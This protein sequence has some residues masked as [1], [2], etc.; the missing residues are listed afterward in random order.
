MLSEIDALVAENPL[1]EKLHARRMLALYRAGRQAMALQAYRDARA[2]LVGEVG[3]EPGP[4]LRALHERILRQD[5]ALELAPVPAVTPVPARASGAARRSRRRATAAAMA[6]LLAGFAILGIARGEDE[7]AA[8][9]GAD[10]VGRVAGDGAIAARFAVGRNPGAI[11]A[12]G[13]SIWVASE[14]DR[15]VTRI[16]GARDRVVTIDVGAEPVGLAYGGGSL[17]VAD[18]SA[19]RVVRVDPASDRVV[20]RI[21]LSNVPRAITAGHGSVWVA[22]AIG[23]AI[24]QIDLERGRVLPVSRVAGSPTAPRRAPGRCGSPASRRVP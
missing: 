10:A 16:D 13:G 20:Q 2:V 14:R 22:S 9:I 15:T 17:W 21:E 23:G 24:T 6:V 1:S 18:G 3:I 11:V 4:E 7:G 5:P 12:G 8:R 19:G